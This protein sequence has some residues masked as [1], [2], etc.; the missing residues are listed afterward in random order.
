MKFSD[1]KHSLRP[2]GA[3]HTHESRMIHMNVLAGKRRVTGNHDQKHRTRKRAKFWNAV[4]DEE[5]ENQSSGKHRREH[6]R[7]F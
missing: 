2:C 3:S 5:R 4:S 7:Q 6:E 1:T